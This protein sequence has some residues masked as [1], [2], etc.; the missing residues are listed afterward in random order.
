MEM[1]FSEAMEMFSEMSSNKD[2]SW[3]M[4]EDVQAAQE[5]VQKEET[6]QAVTKKGQ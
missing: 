6:V 4:S 5:N 2:E 1:F 3:A